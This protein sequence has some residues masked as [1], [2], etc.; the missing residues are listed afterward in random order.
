[1]ACAHDPS[2]PI[3][4]VL[5][6]TDGY[7]IDLRHSPNTCVFVLSSTCVFLVSVVCL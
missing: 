5:C 3:G 4:L 1:M 6:G 2:H 7:L